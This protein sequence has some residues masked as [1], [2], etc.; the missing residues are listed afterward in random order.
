MNNKSNQKKLHF[1]WIISILLILVVALVGAGY[2]YVK[3]VTNNI[4]TNHRAKD[5]AKLKQ[6]KPISILV[7]GTDVGALGRGT[8][9]AG[10]TDTLEL[11]TI[12]PTQRRTVMTAIPRDTLVKINTSHGS[13]YEKINASYAIG[14]DKLAKKQVSELLDVPVD[15]FALVNMG[16]LEKVVD[17]VGGVEVNN[18]FTFTFD[19][20]KYRKGY[21]KLNG[22]QALGYSRMRYD[23]PDNDYGRQRRGQQILI[24]S[25]KK[26]KNQGNLIAANKILMAIKDGVRTD[27]PLDNLSVLYKNYAPAMNSTYN[28][29]LRGKDAKIDG[30]DFQIAMPDQLNDISKQVR[31][32]LGLRPAAVVNEETKLA[33]QQTSW[34]GYKNLEF[35]LPNGAKYNQLTK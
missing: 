9:Y 17:A 33:D 8:S 20:H 16:S 31:N 22:K 25:I 26:F 35:S 30:I 21:Q 6:G 2:G 1:I 5:V 3:S 10:N 15:Y 12:N 11:I 14:G 13:L 18:P 29:Q 23:D 19:G 32:S 27:V 28:E 4:S 7:M 24:S 34:D